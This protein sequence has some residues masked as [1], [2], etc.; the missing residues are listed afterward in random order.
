MAIISNRSPAFV[1]SSPVTTWTERLIYGV[2]V[3]ATAIPLLAVL[4][5]MLVFL[6]QSGLFFQTVPLWRFLTDTQWTPMFTSQ[7]FGIGVLMSGT[8]LVS[9][10]ALL[11]AVPMGVLAAI[12]LSE[13]A[14]PRFKAIV[15]PLLFSLSGIPTIVYGYFALLLITPTLQRIIPDIFIFNALSAGIATGLLVTPIIASLSEDA[16][17]TVD[18]SYR[19]AAYACGLNQFEVIRK[20]LVP[21]ALPGI[22]AAITLA[23]S[24]TLGETMI[25]AIAAGQTPALTFNPLVP[26]ATMTA[27][28][29]QVSLG[30][31]PTD[32]LLFHTIFT[33][34]MVLFLITLALNSLGQW[35]VYRQTASQEVAALPIADGETEPDA[36]VRVMP[37]HM[38]PT[39]LPPLA[40]E[41]QLQRRDIQARI[42]STLG[43]LACLIAP[44]FLGVLTVVTFRLGA[45]HLSWQFLTSFTSSDPEKAGILGAMAGTFWLMLL[46]GLFAV[47]LGIA[48]AIYLEEYVPQ[49]FWSRFIEVNLSNATAIP[50]ILYG[51]LGLAV[52]AKGLH[53]LTGGRSILAASLMMT[54]LTLPLLIS[55]SRLALRQVPKAMIRAG[56]A[57]GMSRWQVIWHIVLPA[58]R[59]SLITGL[60]LS[61][62]RILGETSPLI[63]LGAVEFVTFVPTPTLEGLQSPFTTLTTQIFFWLSRPQSL[64]QEK[65]AA[66]VIVL[67]ALLLVINAIAGMLRDRLRQ[68]SS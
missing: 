4:A 17:S 48:A 12:Y 64:F 66:T 67:G 56:Y 22:I 68:P 19:K 37:K 43:L 61:A 42:F 7:K 14:S 34:G 8:I 16:F 50:G 38:V 62:S 47:P 52:F 60:L 10:I 54:L 53:W 1:T 63:A 18:P 45:A 44:I 55:A 2:L 11:L 33:V 32:S 40:F 13:Y 46:T 41:P 65:A 29:V 9:A 27:F 28:I 6:Y 58:A 59:P 35:L 24:R 5:I 31:V 36:T 15:R 21:Q 20:V 51:L 49:G 57:V 30:D 39:V 26:I 23:A 25:A 3:I